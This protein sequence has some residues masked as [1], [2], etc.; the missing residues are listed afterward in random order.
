MRAPPELE[1]GLRCE[2]WGV[3]PRAGG[4]DDQPAKI[5][6]G[7]ETALFVYHTFKA[8]KR[9]TDK[10]AWYKANP[11]LARFLLDIEKMRAANG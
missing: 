11:D 3:L 1:K 4:I 6:I 5:M 9:A 8:R 7:M 10:G 2:R